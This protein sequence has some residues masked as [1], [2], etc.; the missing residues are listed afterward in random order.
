MTMIKLQSIGL[1]ALAIACAGSLATPVRAEQPP[2]N[3]ADAITSAL[4]N[5]SGDIYRNTGI[6]R[7]AT[8]LFGLSYPEKEFI[9]DA[10]AVEKLYRQGMKA[11]SGNTVVRTADLPNPFTSSLRTTPAQTKSLSNIEPKAGEAVAETPVASPAEVPVVT[12]APRG[13][14]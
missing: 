1:M 14:G 10:N 7:Q 12:P 13:R 8:L 6:D 11:Q 2:E 5:Q 3:I 9:N 4:F